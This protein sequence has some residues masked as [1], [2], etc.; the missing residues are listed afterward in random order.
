MVNGRCIDERNQGAVE[1]VQEVSNDRNNGISSITSRNIVYM[2]IWQQTA[3]Y[4]IDV[5]A[6]DREVGFKLRSQV[7]EY[8][9]N[10]ILSFGLKIKGVAIFNYR[11]NHKNY[12]AGTKP[13]KVPLALKYSARCF[14]SARISFK[15]F[16]ASDVV[17]CFIALSSSII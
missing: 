2:I 16:F 13:F 17:N 7:V 4:A 8:D 11:I 1:F 3:F 10:F 14:F 12:F 5:H 9:R 15:S 6:K